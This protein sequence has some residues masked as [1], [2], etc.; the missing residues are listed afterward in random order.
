[1]AGY[2][3]CYTTTVANMPITGAANLPDPT[4]PFDYLRNG[5]VDRGSYRYTDGDLVANAFLFLGI[6]FRRPVPAGTLPGAD[7]GSVTW[8]QEPVHFLKPA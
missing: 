1:M 3:Y 2:E 4:W 7:I 6:R 5:A 8:E